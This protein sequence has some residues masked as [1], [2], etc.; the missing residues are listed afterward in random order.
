MVNKA[1]SLIY[2][3][4]RTKTDLKDKITAEQISQIDDL[5]T[6]LKS[7]LDSKDHNSIREHSDNLSNLLQE[8]G[9]SAYQQ[10]AQPDPDQTS[11]AP[12]SSADTNS[13]ETQEKVVDGEY[14]EVD[15][16]PSNDAK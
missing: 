14:K 8:I 11:S 9:S 13:S 3:A 4:E 15:D 1:D 5:S 7:S 16:T 6:K 2:T 12:N 10:S